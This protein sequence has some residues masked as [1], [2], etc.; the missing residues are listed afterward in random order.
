ME[1][2]RRQV[3]RLEEVRRTRDNRQVAST[4]RRLE[5]AAGRSENLMPPILEAVR[6]YATLGEIMGVLRN[7]FGEYVPT[8]GI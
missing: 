1:G 7:R 6:A 5:A 4:L 8:W 3:R 2:E